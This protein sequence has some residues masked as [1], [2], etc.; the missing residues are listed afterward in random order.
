MYIVVTGAAGF[1]GIEHRPRPQRAGRD[2]HHRGRQPLARRQVPQHRRLR[3][4]RLPRQG[5]VPRAAVGGRLRRRR[6][7]RPAPGRLLRHHGDRRALHD[8]QQ[9]PLLGGAARAVPEQRHPVHL[10]L[11]RFGLRRRPAFLERREHEAPL[12]VYGYSKFL[13]DQV[14]AAPARR[15]HRAQSPGSATSTC[16]ARAKRTRG[17]W[18]RS[19]STSSTSTWPRAACGSSRAAAATGPGEQ[20]RDF[21]SVDDVVRVNLFFLDHPRSP[22][23]S[24]WARAG[25]RASTRWRAPPSM[26]PR[27]RAA[28]RPL[29][30]DGA[31]VRQGAIEYIA[32]PQQ[33][34]GKYQ[35]FTQADMAALRGRVRRADPDVEDGRRALRRM[36]DGVVGCIPRNLSGRRPSRAAH[37]TRDGG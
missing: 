10:R 16:T 22:A 37:P 8:A 36:A 26:R 14:R 31:Q 34:V 19:R 2:R 1:I 27:A 35:S 12:N 28:R 3:D 15:T 25:R 29:S 6:R 17:A 7:A 9:L 32:F 23:S 11:V 5:G 13:F 4:R 24:T 30:L 33:L 18:R 21:V 20:I